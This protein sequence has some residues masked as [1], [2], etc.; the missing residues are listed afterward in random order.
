MRQRSQC[1]SRRMGMAR[2]AGDEER[3]A[4]SSSLLLCHSSSLFHQSVHRHCSI[5]SFTL[6]WLACY[7]C[8]ATSKGNTAALLRDYDTQIAH[9]ILFIPLHRY[10]VLADGGKLVEVRAEELGAV[11]VVGGVNLLVGR[12]GTV[13][14]AADGEEENV[15]AENV[16]KVEG[17]GDGTALAGVVGLLAVDLDGGLVRRAVRVVVGVGLNV[18][19]DS[20]IFTVQ[21][22]ALT[23][24]GSPPWVSST[25]HLF[26]EPSFLNSSLMY[27]YTHSVVLLMPRLGTRRIENL[28]AT[29]AGMTVLEPG[30]E[31]APSIPWI[32]S[33]GLRM[34]P[35]S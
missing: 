7:V 26:F 32:E 33:E 4:R 2:L 16:G 27:L 25:S 30:A 22:I 35:M 1:P 17:D 34:R 23:I 24:Q 29:D 18:S 10:L 12:V 21:F 19:A 3:C 28:P 13:V 8:N 9:D 6:L 15:E 5:S 20:S 31:K 11:D 14:T